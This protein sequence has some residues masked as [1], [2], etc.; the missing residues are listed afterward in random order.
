[1]AGLRAPRWWISN[2]RRPGRDA[3]AIAIDMAAVDNWL[4]FIQPRTG[5]IG[6]LTIHSRTGSLSDPVQ[7][8]GLDPSLEPFPGN[9]PGIAKFLTRCFLQDPDT[10]EGI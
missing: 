1:M 10:P 2:F 6:R 7:F 5:M 8:G 3:L 4:Y 9:N